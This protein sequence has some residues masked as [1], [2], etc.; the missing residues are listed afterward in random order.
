M[1]IVDPAIER[2]L[3]GLLEQR[4]PDALRRELEQ[5]AAAEE[6]PIIGPLV[7]AECYRLARALD[8]RRV[9]EL[10]SG[11]GYS[12]LWFAAA[13]RDNGGGQVVHT[14]WEDALSQQARSYLERAGLADQVRFKVGEA[15]ALLT[16]DADVHDIVFMDIDKHGYPG[17]LPAIKQ[18]LRVGGLLIVDN[19]LWHGRVLDAAA[20]DRDTAGVRALTHQIFGDRDFAPTINPLRDGFLV[21]SRVT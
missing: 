1:N 15:V 6:F 9:F 12:T 16:A 2:Y 11:F 7:G 10:G 3:A 13:L 19:L 17:A 5:R 20:S 4:Y 8:A 14:V 21:A 18:H